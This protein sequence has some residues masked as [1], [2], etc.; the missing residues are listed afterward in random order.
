MKIYIME[1]N[2]YITYRSGAA[3]MRNVGAVLLFDRIKCALNDAM[4]ESCKYI[5]DLITFAPLASQ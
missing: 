4:L 5:Y 3:E 1:K 2:Q